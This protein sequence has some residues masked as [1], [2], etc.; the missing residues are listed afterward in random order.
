MMS[1]FFG[2][3][4]DPSSPLHMSEIVQILQA[5]LHNDVRISLETGQGQHKI[6]NST[7]S[8]TGL[9]IMRSGMCKMGANF[10]FEI[11]LD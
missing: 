8:N 2:M 7:S 6:L 9:L 3:F 10:P 5:P 11:F 1:K 4:F